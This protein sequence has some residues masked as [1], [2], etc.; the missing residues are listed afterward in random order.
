MEIILSVPIFRMFM[1]L[2]ILFL[3]GTEVYVGVFFYLAGSIQ[4]VTHYCQQNVIDTIT[5]L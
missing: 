5:G 2:C 1:V 3:E 4:A